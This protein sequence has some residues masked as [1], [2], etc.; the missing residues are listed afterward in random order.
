MRGFLIDLLKWTGLAAVAYVVLLIA[1]G[2]VSRFGADRNL[3]YMRGSDEMLFNRVRDIDTT[4]AYDILVTGSSHA[5]RGFDPRIF[6]RHGLRLFNLGSSAQTPAQARVLLDHHLLRVHPRLVIMEVYPKAMDHPGIESA[7]DVVSNDRIDLSTVRMALATRH[8]AV[9]NTLIYATFRQLAGL[10]R[11]RVEPEL[12]A[13]GDRYIRG[14]YVQRGDTTFR[15]GRTEPFAQ[16]T[17]LPA[18]QRRF[19][20][21]VELIRSTGAQVVLVHTPVMPGHR[22]APTA[23]AE[24]NAFCTGLAPYL[25]MSEL[26]APTDTALFYDGHHLTQRGVDRFN[27]ALIERLQGMGLL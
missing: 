22:L 10:D 16:W 6:D 27:A 5:Y 24:F 26:F 4:A 12:R 17:P 21:N 7:L 13:N 1:A 2:T 15:L 9:L 8:I 3:K 20:E 23:Q 25:D 14:G 19:T 18:Q 11:D